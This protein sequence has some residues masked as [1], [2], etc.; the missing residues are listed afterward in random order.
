[1]KNEKLDPNEKP[2]KINVGGEMIDP[3]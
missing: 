1:M 2:I 3:N